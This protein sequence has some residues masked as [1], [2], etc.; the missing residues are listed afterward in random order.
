M[1]EYTTQRFDCENFATLCTCRTSSK[2]LMNTMGIAVGKHNGNPHGF[3]VFVSRVD[4]APQVFLLEPQ[5]GMVD[6][7]GYEVDYAIFG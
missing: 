1:P 3:N 5:T 2:Y 7:D 6:P 4:D